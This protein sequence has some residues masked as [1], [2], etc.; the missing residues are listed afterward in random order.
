MFKKRSYLREY[1]DLVETL[2]V[3]Q[4][5]CLDLEQSRMH[6]NRMRKIKDIMRQHFGELEKRSRLGYRR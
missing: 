3:L 1:E 6:G 4:G 5:A 2:E